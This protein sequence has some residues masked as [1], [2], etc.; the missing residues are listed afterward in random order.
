MALDVQLS[1]LLGFNTALSSPISWIDETDVQFT[2]GRSIV[3]YDTETRLQRI[4][5]P[6]PETICITA[7]TL[8]PNKKYVFTLLSLPART[9]HNML[10]SLQVCRLR[11]IYIQ[12]HYECVHF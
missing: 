8:S 12:P 9:F 5:S 4:V 10:F 3:R 7:I 1:S 2:T 11:R 6:N